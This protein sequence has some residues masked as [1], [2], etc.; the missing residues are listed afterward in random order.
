[1]YCK[2]SNCGSYRQRIS[3]IILCKDS[4]DT[5]KVY[6]DNPERFEVN[7]NAWVASANDRYL[8][9]VWIQENVWQSCCVVFLSKYK[10]IIFKGAL[11]GL[12]QLKAL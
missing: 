1:M 11:S 10:Q 2:I 5:V 4:E 8:N 6:N 3:Y 12:R 9:W 7:G